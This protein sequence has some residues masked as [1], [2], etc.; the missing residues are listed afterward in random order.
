MNLN[1][2]SIFKK[3][4]SRIRISFIIKNLRLI[5]PIMLQKQIFKNFV[6]LGLSRIDKS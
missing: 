1:P 3:I 6:K 4:K 2:N 5:L